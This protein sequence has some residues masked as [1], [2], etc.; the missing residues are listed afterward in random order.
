MNAECEPASETVAVEV[1]VPLLEQPP[2][3]LTTAGTM[4]SLEL[5]GSSSSA[6]ASRTPKKK[7]VASKWT[8]RNRSLCSKLKKTEAARAREKLSELSEAR[9]ELCKKEMECLIEKHQEELEL[10]NMKKEIEKTKLLYYKSKI[11]KL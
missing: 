1:V 8:A 3:V 10:I 9:R 11:D 5:P 4:V 2:D 7:I 6:V